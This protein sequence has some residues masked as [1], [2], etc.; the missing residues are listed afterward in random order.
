MRANLEKRN[1]KVAS[2]PLSQHRNHGDLIFTAG[3]IGLEPDGSVA[4]GFGRQM[5]LAMESLTA[6]LEEAGGSLAS[7]LKVTIFLVDRGD[8]AE[9]NEIYARYFDD[10]FPARSTIITELALP[11]LLFEIEVVAERAGA[12]G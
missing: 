4:D 6:R 7:V 3:Q 9:M 12:A 11:G 8:F 2:I 1:S 5:Q 10:P